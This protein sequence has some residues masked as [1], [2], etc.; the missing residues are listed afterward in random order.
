[1]DSIIIEL[2]YL[3]FEKSFSF[4]NKG[5]AIEN[6][7]STES[8]LL[9]AVLFHF[10]CILFSVFLM[11]YSN[12]GRKVRILGCILK[13]LLRFP[14]SALSDFSHIW[15]ITRVAT[16]SS[17]LMPLRLC[18]AATMVAS[19]ETNENVCNKSNILPW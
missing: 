12:V 15:R 6:Q 7:S 17:F 1:M 14:S 2:E 11:P 5:D 3:L 13:I 10:S 4:V 9:N 18:A 19:F 8:V 16:L